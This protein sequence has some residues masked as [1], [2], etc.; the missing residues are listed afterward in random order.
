M[1]KKIKLKIE[2]MHCQSCQ[3]LIETEIDV[4][5]GVN[6]VKVEIKKEQAEIEFDDQ[7]LSVRQLINQIEKIGYKAA[8]FNQ[9]SENENTAESVRKKSNSFWL[10]ILVLIGLFVLIGGY[11]LISRMG[12]FELLAKLNEGNVSYGLILLIGL[13]AGFHCVGMCGGLVIAYSAN[14]L[15]K[16]K[17]DKRKFMP[18][19][20]YNIGR[21][22]S[23]TIIGGILGAVG[24]F[25]AIN[26]TF[27][28]TVILAAGIFMILMGFTFIFNWDI[29]HKI[30][31][32]T[33]QFIARFLFNQKHSKKPKGPFIVGLFNGLMPCGPL[34]AMQLYALTTGSFSKGAL[35]M[36]IYALGTI[37]LMFGFGAFLSMISNNRIKQ[38]IKISGGLVIILGL[39]MIN[40]GLTNFGYGLS[41]SKNV[42]QKEYVVSGD[43][44]E[45]QT[46]EMELSYLGYTP[47]VLYI[48]KGVPVRWV[49][50][51]KQMSGCT[52]A[53][54]IEELGIRK[55][56]S[57]GENIIEFTP[58]KVGEL[59]FSCWMK[60]V[61][62]KFIVTEND[63]NPTKLEIDHQAND[64]PS[65]TCGASEG[66]CGC[67][68]GTIRVNN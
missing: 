61:W 44:S 7:Q 40:R 66:G 38:I 5:L 26:P 58:E 27:T 17:E 28:G 24:S 54:M 63:Y 48:K 31:L 49:I 47:N 59:K 18:H 9:L 22:I 60:M 53:I 56:L 42:S 62:G 4:M 34:Q 1:L 39:I 14:D 2:G 25:F 29:L 3:T 46:V 11:Y 33:P 35:S 37:P 68:G 21:L 8:V 10:G 50:N 30:K 13:L 52:D 65:G 43:I 32:R 67:G 12:G 64:L 15:T 20:Q 19:M 23:Y 55:D 16:K 57:L 41:F 36:A 51:V 6:T 45:Y